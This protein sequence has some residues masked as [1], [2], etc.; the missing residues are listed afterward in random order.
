MSTP[1]R[2][3]ATEVEYLESD[4][5]PLGET[6]VHVNLIFGL[7]AVLDNWFKSRQ[8]VLVGSNQLLYFLVPHVYVVF[9]TSP[10]PRRT[11]KLWEEGKAPEVVMEISSRSTCSPDLEDKLSLSELIGVK[12]YFVF[13]PEYRLQPQPLFGFRMRGRRDETLKVKNSVVHSKQLRLDLVDT[14][15]TLRLRDPK[16]GQFLFTPGEEN[17]ARQQAEAEVERLR[18]ELAR[19]QRQPRADKK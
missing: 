7:K 17:E 11:W 16:T 4:G 19:L 9:G 18:A 3:I 1:L 15:R 10:E 13:D 2:K 8:D 14:A 12:E 5:E 6:G